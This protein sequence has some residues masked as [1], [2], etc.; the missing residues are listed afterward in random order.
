MAGV[1]FNSEGV[2]RVRMPSLH[3][4][5]SSSGTVSLSNWRNILS[6]TTNCRC[7]FPLILIFSEGIS[8]GRI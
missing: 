4:M 3:E 2:F 8:E 1:F 5:F 7:M 6:E